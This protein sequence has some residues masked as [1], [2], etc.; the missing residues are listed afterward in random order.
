MINSGGSAVGAGTVSFHVESGAVTVGRH[1]TFAEDVA[2][3]RDKAVRHATKKCC[4]GVTQMLG[5]SL[6]AVSSVFCAIET[7]KMPGRTDLPR[8]VDPLSA[9]FLSAF[10]GATALGG[11]YCGMRNVINGGREMAALHSERH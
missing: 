9:G 10:L 2:A 4:Y 5:A 7:A 3:A 1:V 6:L 8:G 11:M